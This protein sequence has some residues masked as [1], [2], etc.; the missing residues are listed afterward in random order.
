MYNNIIPVFCEMAFTAHLSYKR[1]RAFA[2]I[3]C[4][5]IFGD[6][7]SCVVVHFNIEQKI[8]I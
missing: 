2:R 4:Y 5:L 1:H 7:L 6:F 8:I 3:Y